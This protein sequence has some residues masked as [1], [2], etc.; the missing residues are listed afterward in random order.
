MQR[1]VQMNV[2]DKEFVSERLEVQA[3]A[4]LKA[5]QHPSGSG[6]STDLYMPIQDADEENYGQTVQ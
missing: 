1:A 6:N 4:K 5:S 3:A 2:G